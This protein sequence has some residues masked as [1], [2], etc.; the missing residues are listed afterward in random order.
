MKTKIF[1]TVILLLA[2]ALAFGQT[3]F[4]PCNSLA[5]SPVTTNCTD[6]LGVANYADSPIPIGSVDISATGFTIVD[7]GS[8]YSSSTT[9]IVTDFYNTPGAAGAA[10]TVTVDPATGA[11]TAITGT[12][13]G[14]GYVALV[15]TIVDP[16]GTGAGAKKTPRIQKQQARHRRL[17]VNIR[18]I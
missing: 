15:V 7:G 5:T 14:V 2:G 18:P 9:A 6:C 17:A 1:L 11:I 3:N 8:G 12:S 13:G 16:L 4:P 10:A